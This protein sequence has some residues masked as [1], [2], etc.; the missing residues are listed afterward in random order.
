MRHLALGTAAIGRPLYI[1]LRQENTSPFSPDAFRQNAWNVLENAYQKGIRYFDT[2]PNYGM[3]EELLI[4]W[5]K[6]KNDNNIEVATKWGY[7]YVANFA[8]D[9][10]QHETK[11]HSLQKLKEQWQQSKKL[12]P[13][14]TTYQI[15]SATFETG[16]LK[17]E[18]ILKRLAELKE[19]HQLLIG[20]T[21]TG[22]NQV[23]VI[24]KAL[25]VTVDGIQLFDTFQVTYNILDQSIEEIAKELNRQNKRIIVKEAL[26]NGRLFPNDRYPH[27]KQLYNSVLQL[28]DKYQVGVDAIVLRFCM[29]RLQPFTVLS[30]AAITEHTDQNLKAL[31]I[32]LEE[33]EVAS[34]QQFKVDAKEYWEERKKLSW[35]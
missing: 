9:A 31:S 22:A 32:K 17:N 14:L 7:T 8:P 5:L 15:H 20:I 19:S 3:A 1:N 21:T 33:E 18:A 29:D 28:A 16:V 27:Y 10:A 26:A 11:E 12:L 13:N 35:T 25:S 23:D 30:G 4:E 34:L 24:K 6:S 2:A